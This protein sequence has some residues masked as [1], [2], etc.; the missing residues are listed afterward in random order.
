M[1]RKTAVYGKRR[2]K[3]KY[4]ITL[5]ISILNLTYFF[6]KGGSTWL[7]RERN[8]VTWD[9]MGSLVIRVPLMFNLLVQ[10]WHMLK[11]T[12]LFIMRLK[13]WHD[14]NR[15]FGC[16]WINHL[17]MISLNLNLRLYI[18]LKLRLQYKRSGPREGTSV[19]K[20][21]DLAYTHFRVCSSNWS[22]LYYWSWV[23]KRTVFITCHSSRHSCYDLFQLAPCGGR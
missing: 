8:A 3:I 11:N 13:I 6:F 22:T 16:L 20:A 17:R 5:H 2:N 18:F 15:R 12:A 19:K 9:S 4:Y 14:K 1:N 21:F 23:R 10:H 7:R